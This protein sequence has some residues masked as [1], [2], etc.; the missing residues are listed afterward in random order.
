MKVN[1][2]WLAI[3]AGVPFGIGLYFAGAK[4]YENW[5]FVN[6]WQGQRIPREGLSL[7]PNSSKLGNPENARKDLRRFY[8]ALVAFRSK[9][10]RM[11][12][13]PW[14]LLEAGKKGEVSIGPDDYVNPDVRYT[15]D[16]SLREQLASTDKI[17]LNQSYGFSWLGSQ[18]NGRPKPDFPPRDKPIKWVASSV[19]ERT[20]AKVKPD[21]S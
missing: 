1:R 4:I 6:F 17:D 7:H 20:N 19:Y 14:E 21:G 16:Q 8:V 12:A 3:G 18:P 2:R 13:T 5:V 11:P 10:G 15:E 9:Y